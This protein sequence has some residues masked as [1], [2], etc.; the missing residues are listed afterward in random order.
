MGLQWHSKKLPHQPPLDQLIKS[1][2]MIWN[3]RPLSQDHCCAL[4]RRKNLSC[5]MPFIFHK[6]FGFATL[7]L[8]LQEPVI[9]GNILF[10][11]QL[12]LNYFCPL[13]SQYLEGFFIMSCNFH[14][15][16][17]FNFRWQEC[18]FILTLAS[19]QQYHLGVT[20]LVEFPWLQ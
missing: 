6:C 16:S 10:H 12:S 19:T 3:N 7:F 2:S 13:R 8:C 4:W 5:I 18:I 9:L 14:P 20:T 17:S 1:T 15:R 11:W